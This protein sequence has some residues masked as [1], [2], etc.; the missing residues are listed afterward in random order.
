MLS[1]NKAYFW[2]FIYM[3]ISQLLAPTLF[4]S[5]DELGVLFMFVIIALD[6]AINRNFKRYNGLFLVVG[7]MSFYAIYSMTALNFN[8]KS[9]IVHDFIIELKPFVAFF[10]GYAFA[11]RFTTKQKQILK[12]ITIVMVVLLMIIFITGLTDLL[13]KHIA[14]FGSTAFILFL[15]YM[16]CGVKKDGTISRNDFGTAIFILAIGLLCTRSKY[17]GEAV[18]ALFMFLLYKPGTF[19]KISHKQVL[20]MLCVV[21]AV[22]A[23]SWSKINYY[24]LTGNNDTFDAD[25]VHTFARPEL[26]GGMILL[27]FDY[28]LLGSGLA[29]YA[30]FASAPS[31]N[32]SLVYAKYDLNQ[33]FGLSE[34]YY[35]FICDAFY[36]SLA[37][38]GLIGIGLFIYFFVWIYQK[39]RLTLHSEGKYIFSVGVLVIIYVLI[40]NVGGTFF[41]QSGGLLS[42]MIL[43][44]ITGKYRLTTKEDKQEIL[45]SDYPNNN[46]N[47]KQQ[48]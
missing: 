41:T 18:M 42:M 23:V 47:N 37:Q 7:I 21:G 44:Q 45:N 13:L 3:M 32:Y 39:L 11:P 4:K 36:A 34:Q 1:I 15:I 16:F 25:T 40:E 12:G 24:F 10:I 33:I 27:L 29:S 35:A 8:I 9:A 14:Y 22:L 19:R 28:P 5:A 2:I 20:I 6:L 31:V 46:D 48:I 17:Y 38:F 26:Y 30:T 43:G